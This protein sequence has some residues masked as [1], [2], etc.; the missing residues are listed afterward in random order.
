ML[1]LTVILGSV[2]SG[3]I[4]SK[5]KIR[6]LYLTLFSVGICL[7]PVGAIFIISTGVYMKYTVLMLSFAIIQ[8]V[9][10]VFSIFALSIIQQLTPNN[11]IGKVMAYTATFSL[12]AQPLG[13]IL[14]LIHILHAAPAKSSEQKDLLLSHSQ[15][16]HKRGRRARQW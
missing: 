11:M 15:L 4:V 6:K 13:Q 12:C 5:F 10:C 3:L 8:I 16:P 7:L 1:G 14:S 2:I 9:A